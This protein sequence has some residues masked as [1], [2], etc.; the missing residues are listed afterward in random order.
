[1]NKQKDNAGIV[2]TIIFLTLFFLTACTT[3]I[4]P[5][6]TNSPTVAPV[7]MPESNWDT[8]ELI[9]QAEQLSAPSFVHVAEERL[10]AWTGSQGTEARHFSRG[11]EGNT[12]IMALSAYFPQEQQLFPIDRGALMLWL[13]R[14]DTDFDLRLQVATFSDTGVALVG[15]VTVSTQRTRHYSA[16]ALDDR[17]IRIVWSG[18]LGEV[19]NLYLHQVDHFGRPVSG[20]LLRIDADYP[21]LIQ[22]NSGA[23]HLFWLE[24]NGR[25]VYQA[26]FDEVGDPSLIN[27]ERISSANISGTD[28]INH[29]S[30][31]FDGVGTY[32][33]WNIRRIDDT[34]AVLMSYG[35]L[36]S[37]NFSVASPLQ[38]N[39]GQAIQWLNPAQAIQNPLPIVANSDDDLLLLWMEDGLM[40]ETEQIVESGRLIGLPNIHTTEDELAVTW[41]QI[42]SNGYAN[43]FYSSRS[44]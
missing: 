43:L 21:A 3:D 42:T 15:P 11:I 26:E 10:F 20:D 24:D 35:E 32:L 37:N 23:S 27:I 25:N 14:T 29:F 5:V 38:T 36:D 12:Q 9:A 22:D 18:G 31:G 4:A 6:A 7:E 17:Q 1:M 39:T 33:F 28:T 16:I 40:I 13:D 41:A 19:T 8:L 30:I 2:P 44:R 34:Q